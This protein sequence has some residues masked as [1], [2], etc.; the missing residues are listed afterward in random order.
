MRFQRSRPLI[1]RCL[2]IRHGECS[3]KDG[4][5][6][7]NGAIF[8]K[9]IQLLAYA[10]E[11]DIIERSSKRN[12]TAA[13]SAIEQEPTNMGLAVSKEGKRKYILS[14]RRDVRRVD[15]QITTDNYTF[16]TVK[17]F[18]MA[19]PLPP[20]MMSLWRSKSKITTDALNR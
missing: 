15:S 17:E 18:I 20:K 1:M 16:D 12:V 13:F 5:I 4:N 6:H 14:T 19:P 8:R 7:R 10:D 2:Q 9:D 11:I 3:E